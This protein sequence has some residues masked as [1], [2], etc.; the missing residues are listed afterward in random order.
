[1]LV[2]RPFWRNLLKFFG[3]TAIYPTQSARKSV[4]CVAPHTS[5]W[6][7]P[8]GLL[9]YLSI[10]RKPHFLIKKEWF[11]FPL[12]LF[13]KMF[14]GIPVDRN[15]NT[16]TVDQIIEGLAHKDDYNI[17]VTPEGTRSKRNHWKTGFWRIASG[18]GIVIELAKIDYRKKELG[19]FETFTPTADMEADMAYIQ[20]KYSADMAK[21]PEKYSDGR[22][23]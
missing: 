23:E 8:L 18:A 1:M 16:S 7:F 4:I 10:G 17:A 9:Y 5:N 2:T 11:I 15:K 22:S 14:G 12:N 3:W 21:Y 19:I 13:F 6:D 20:S